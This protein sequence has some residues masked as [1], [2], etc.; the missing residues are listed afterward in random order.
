MSHTYPSTG[1]IVETRIKIDDS[2]MERILLEKATQ[3][4]SST[5]EVTDAP[6]ANEGFYDTMIWIV[7]YL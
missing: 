7:Q 4:L 2:L 3:N 5:S 1:E 6:E